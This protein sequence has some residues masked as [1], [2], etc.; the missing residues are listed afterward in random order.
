MWAPREVDYFMGRK[1]KD[2]D[3][4]PSGLRYFTKADLG[5]DWKM[6]DADV[7]HRAD[8]LAQSVGVP[9]KVTS[10][11]RSPAHN[12]SI[13]GAPDSMHV[14]GRALDLWF[15]DGAFFSNA[16]RYVSQARALGLTGIGLYQG[17]P[18]LHVDNREKP[19][20][21]A[22]LASGKMVS[23]AEGLGR[24]AKTGAPFALIALLLVLLFLAVKGSKGPG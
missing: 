2:G 23:L 24:A 13:G 16:A 9:V 5:A 19:G 14:Q 3:F 10:G 20:S 6:L 22:K 4:G 15:T 7:V 18:L 21:W 11:Y 12:K 1:L 8:K 17:K